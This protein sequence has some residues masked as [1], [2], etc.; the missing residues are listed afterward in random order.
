[1]TKHFLNRFVTLYCYLKS[2]AVPSI[3]LCLG[4]VSNKALEVQLMYN[5]S[6]NWFRLSLAF[7]RKQDHAGIS[8]NLELPFIEFEAQIYDCRHW[9]YKK[10]R[11]YLPGEEQA[12]LQGEE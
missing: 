8:F 6:W 7:T 12:E 1:M 11:W 3:G 5:P 9:N 2:P 10:D 4:T